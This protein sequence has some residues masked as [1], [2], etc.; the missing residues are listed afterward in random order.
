MRQFAA[1]MGVARAKS[2]AACP[3][4]VS[5]SSESIAHAFDATYS[6][7]RCLFSY[8]SKFF[9]RRALD[10]EDRHF[11]VGRLSR[12]TGKGVQETT[13]PTQQLPVTDSMRTRTR[14]QLVPT[15]V[16]SPSP[17]QSSC[18][19]RKVAVV[20]PIF[21]TLVHRSLSSQFELGYGDGS[22]VG[23]AGTVA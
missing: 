12:L 19:F 3:L 2:A 15:P 1:M 14:A 9:F 23:T 4:F 8:D 18:S 17:L 10:F 21:I 13:Q 7:V 20:V 22:Q 11:P 6:A 16:S 5:V